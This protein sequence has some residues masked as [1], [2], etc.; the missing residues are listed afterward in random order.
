MKSN[1]FN[2]EAFVNGGGNILKINKLKINLPSPTT[3]SGTMSVPCTSVFLSIRFPE[4]CI[5]D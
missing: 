2:I 1:M 5:L 4:K 3:Y